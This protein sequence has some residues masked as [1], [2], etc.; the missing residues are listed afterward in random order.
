V[1]PD[2]RH[3]DSPAVEQSV[4]DSEAQR[5]FDAEAK[6]VRALLAPA[7]NEPDDTAVAGQGHQDAE[8]TFQ[9]FQ[10]LLKLKDQRWAASPP[11]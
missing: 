9:V 11:L 2:A 5:L 8:G 1:R 10:R 6:A 3:A 7:F 4:A